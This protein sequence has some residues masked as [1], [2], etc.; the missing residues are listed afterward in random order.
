MVTWPGAHSQSLPLGVLMA[1]SSLGYVLWPEPQPPLQHFLMSPLLAFLV[2]I[3]N[4]CSPFLLI[5]TL[6]A[7]ILSIN[8]YSFEENNQVGNS[9]RWYLGRVKNLGHISS[10][11]DTAVCLHALLFD[12]INIRESSEIDHKQLLIPTRL[13][14][15]PRDV[16]TPPSSPPPPRSLGFKSKVNPFEENLRPVLL[17]SLCST[18]ASD[19]Y[20]LP[21]HTGHFFMFL[22]SF[23][24][25]YFYTI[26]K[27]YLLKGTRSKS[28][29]LISRRFACI[30]A[31]LFTWENK[32]EAAYFSHIGI[33]CSY[34]MLPRPSHGRGESK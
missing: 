28:N 19:S 30:S 11:S 27:G 33:H 20:S 18:Q 5:D 2:S 34:H 29:I 3:Q 1:H 12:E 17:G 10:P 15:L 4:I 23:L 24:D 21:L 32:L 26:L 16:L 9:Q 13:Q 7:S 31:G 14:H 25:L 22:W 8:F 6:S